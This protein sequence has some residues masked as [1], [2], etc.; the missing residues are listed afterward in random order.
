MTFCES[1]VWVCKSL[2]VCVCVY[3]YAWQS[4]R[5]SLVT[6]GAFQSTL[7]SS[8]PVNG[9][10]LEGRDI[11]F[12][13]LFSFNAQHPTCQPPQLLWRRIEDNI[14]LLSE[15]FIR[16][17][18]SKPA[19]CYSTDYI[20]FKCFPT[21]SRHVFFFRIVHLGEC[22][23]IN[24][25]RTMDWNIMVLDATS[26]QGNNCDR[27]GGDKTGNWKKIDGVQES[28]KNPIKGGLSG[29]NNNTIKGLASFRA[30]GGLLSIYF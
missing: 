20:W 7:G 6:S 26:F 27:F 24:P 13:F 1:S 15:I 14:F 25:N 28:G 29:N 16:H 4:G 9:N 22:C 23:H 30:I 18:H 5:G 3:V 11:T 21:W 10:V 8:L 2:C 19:Q 17:F 12:F